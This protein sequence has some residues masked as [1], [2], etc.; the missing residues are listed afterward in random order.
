M[1]HIFF[2]DFVHL[3]KNDFHFAFAIVKR[4]MFARAL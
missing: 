2:G 1:L 3:L 4:F